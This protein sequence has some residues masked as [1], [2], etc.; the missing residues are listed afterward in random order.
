M[1]TSDCFEERPDLAKRINRE[2]SLAE[3]HP[4][5]VNGNEFK[6]CVLMTVCCT[7]LA[8]IGGVDSAAILATFFWEPARDLSVDSIEYNPHV[9]ADNIRHSQ[10]QNYWQI[11]TIFLGPLTGTNTKHV[12]QTGILGK[13]QLAQLIA[14]LLSVSLPCA[15]MQTTIMDSLVLKLATIM[16][17]CRRL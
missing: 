3:D 15:V 7:G 9:D 14:D 8:N 13:T 16:H 5:R 6:I 4:N 17:R 11:F 10:R 2:L 12:T 1:L